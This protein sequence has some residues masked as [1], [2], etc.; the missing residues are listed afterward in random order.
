MLKI[1]KTFLY[2]SEKSGSVSPLVNPMEIMSVLEA[3]ISKSETFSMHLKKDI[4]E[5][6]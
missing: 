3:L 6:D 1:Q 5:W 2:G 4:I